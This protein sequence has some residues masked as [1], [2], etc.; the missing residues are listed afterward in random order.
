MP[1]IS[2][3]SSATVALVTL[4]RGWYEGLLVRRFQHVFPLERLLTLR[5]QRQWNAFLSS[6]LWQLSF[7]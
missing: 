7:A 3:V 5:L 6:Y 2:I 1:P 4:R